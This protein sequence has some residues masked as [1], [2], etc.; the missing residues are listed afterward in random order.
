M[1]EV[2]VDSFHQKE[3]PVIEL[4][5]HRGPVRINGLTQHSNGIW[6][7]PGCK[8]LHDLMK[9]SLCEVCVVKGEDA[10]NVG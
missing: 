3:K 1:A 4:L 8:P 2:L 9:L 10:M 6:T 7:A 5:Q